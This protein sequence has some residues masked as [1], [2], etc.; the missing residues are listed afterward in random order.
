MPPPKCA[1]KLK[2]PQKTFT[3]RPSSTYSPVFC[4]WQYQGKVWR[5]A[6]LSS[7]V[8]REMRCLCYINRSFSMDTRGVCESVRGTWHSEL[9]VRVQRCETFG[10]L[11]PRT[12]CS[13]SMS[14]QSTKTD[15]ATL[16]RPSI[17]FNLSPLLLNSQTFLKSCLHSPPHS[18]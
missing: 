13:S 1:S 7:I 4:S 6:F 12:G 10:Q 3:L 17:L 16:P 15:T 11:A 18:T 8:V 14:L 2:W 5:R 9:G